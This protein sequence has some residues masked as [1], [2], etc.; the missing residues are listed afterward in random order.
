[1]I[2]LSVFASGSGTNAEKIY[3]YFKGNDLVKIDTV[4]VSN[5]NAGIIQRSKN[6]GADVIILDKK[7]HTQLI[8]N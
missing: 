4:V 5:S 7:V 1:M 3:E 8:V 6:W 2:K